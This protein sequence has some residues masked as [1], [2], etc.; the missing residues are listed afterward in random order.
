MHTY[1]WLVKYSD[2]SVMKKSAAHYKF[3]KPLTIG[4]FSTDCSESKNAA[5]NYKHGYNGGYSGIFA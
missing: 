3:D 4:E 5:T 2:Y 1:T